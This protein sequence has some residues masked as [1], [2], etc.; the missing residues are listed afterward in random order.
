MR[1]LLSLCLLAS[2][3][4]CVTSKQL[5]QHAEAQHD[6]LSAWQPAPPPA[7][8]LIP[9]TDTTHA[10]QPT[11]EA[12]PDSLPFVKVPRNPHKPTEN[13]EIEGAKRGFLARL[14]LR[15]KPETPVSG[16]VANAT[17]VPRKCKNCTFNVVGGNQTNADK[18]SRVLGDGAR[19]TEV[20][21]NKAP[22]ILSS[23]SSTQHAL[24][25]AGNIQATT[26]NN[27]TPQLVA[28]VQQA[29]D[30][31]AVLAKPAGIVGAGIVSLIVVG[32]LCYWVVLWRKKKAAENLV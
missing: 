9:A 15:N 25:G 2:L 5:P 16:G 24:L 19:N 10:G 18:K 13:Y 8:Y 27:N 1:H 11:F 23:D 7:N 26:G 22:A 30:W 17:E 28:P 12:L 32:G 29:A 14:F 31:R 4:S 21:K 20:G 6:T 3:T